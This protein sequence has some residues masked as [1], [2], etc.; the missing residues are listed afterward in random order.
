MIFGNFIKTFFLHQNV[1]VCKSTAFL[2]VQNK[3]LMS[4]LFYSFADFT[5]EVTEKL[6]Q[7]ILSA[8]VHSQKHG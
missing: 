6:A 1:R 4:S 7:L 8:A 5:V 2:E 3:I